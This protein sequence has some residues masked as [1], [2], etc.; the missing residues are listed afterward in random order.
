MRVSFPCEY[1]EGWHFISSLVSWLLRALRQEFIA[2]T[3]GRIFQTCSSMVRLVSYISLSF[4][5]CFYLVFFDAI[6]SFIVSIN[7]LLC[8]YISV[9]WFS[10]IY[11]LHINISIFAVW[12]TIQDV[13]SE[14]I[15][16]ARNFLEVSMY[17]I[18]FSKVSDL[19]FSSVCFSSNFTRDSNIK[20]TNWAL[21]VIRKSKNTEVSVRGL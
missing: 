8:F 9:F 6:H 13:P 16:L 17:K 12:D 11:C 14:D 21:S 10:S 7:H 18:I 5:S 2:Q 3:C 4:Q 19:F 20:F 1:P 15:C